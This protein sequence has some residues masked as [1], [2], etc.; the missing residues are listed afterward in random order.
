MSRRYYDYP[1]AYVR[2]IAPWQNQML[3]NLFL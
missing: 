1:D 2:L 3:N